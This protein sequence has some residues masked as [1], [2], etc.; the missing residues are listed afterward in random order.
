MVIEF[1]AFGGQ[2]KGWAGDEKID[3]CLM[4]SRLFFLVKIAVS[5]PL[6]DF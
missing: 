5:L 6:L 1:M 3:D 4:N 2:K